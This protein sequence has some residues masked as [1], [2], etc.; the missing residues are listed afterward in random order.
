M[1]IEKRNAPTMEQVASERRELEL[2]YEMST[3][4]FLKYGCD[5]KTVDEDDA[6]QWEYLNEQMEVLQA[7]AVEKL[8]AVPVRGQVTLSNN[9]FDPELLAA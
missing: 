5:N 3:E 8:Y 7:A 9:C 1:P 2:R 6:M 4:T